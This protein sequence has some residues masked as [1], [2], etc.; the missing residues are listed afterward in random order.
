MT[1]SLTALSADEINKF[2]EEHLPPGFVEKPKEEPQKKAICLGLLTYTGMIH[3][4]TM[5]CLVQAVM[6]CA[7]QGWG[8]T[9]ILREADSMVA[10]GRSLLASQFLQNPSAANCTDLVMVD[11]DLEW[12]GEEFLRLCSHNVD[13]VGAAYPYK[14]DSGDF[15]LRWPADG[16]M[17]ENGL[18][19]VQA[20]TPGFLR[21]TRRALDRIAKDMPWIEFKDRFNKDGQRSWMF[22]DNLQRPSGVYD[23]GYV[24]CERARQAGYKIFLDPD[25]NLTHIGLRAYNHGTIRQWLDRKA[26]SFDRLESE[27]PDVPPL[28]LMRKT[29]GE[30]I[31]LEE[32]RKKHAAKKAA[33]G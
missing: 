16:L 32:E 27:F 20:V 33:Q 17:E 26:Q 8:F 22:F 31:D 29:M 3:T 13:I 12:H 9:Y 14:D 30:K 23:E 18:W 15:P 25:M 5:M 28:V 4:R 10:R 1:T 7:Q 21:V 24:F 2:V 6:Q 19:Q 11:T